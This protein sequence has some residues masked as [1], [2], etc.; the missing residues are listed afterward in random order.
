[1]EC[2]L[3]FDSFQFVKQKFGFVSV[4]FLTSYRA[5]QGLHTRGCVV[6]VL[7]EDCSHEEESGGP[8]WEI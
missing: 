4:W 7:V 3:N 2:N 6:L 1:M 8:P 5:D